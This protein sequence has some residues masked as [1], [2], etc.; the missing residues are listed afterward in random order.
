MAY[1]IRKM[2]AKCGSMT[3]YEAYNGYIGSYFM[4]PSWSLNPQNR[5]PPAQEELVTKWYRLATVLVTCTKQAES[6]LNEKVQKMYKQL[7]QSLLVQLIV[8]SFELRNGKESL[9]SVTGY[10]TLLPELINLIFE[11][12]TQRQKNN[13]LGV[14]VT[15]MENKEKLAFETLDKLLD[16]QLKKSASTADFVKFIPL[17]ILPVVKAIQIQNLI[18]KGA[19]KKIMKI[20]AKLLQLLPINISTMQS[21]GPPTSHSLQIKQGL[22]FLKVFAANQI[23]E[24]YPIEI[25]VKAKLRDY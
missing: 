14:L 20:L 4:K 8:K 23:V 11:S 12:L 7:A 3:I 21:S 2:V 16:S 13:L 10:D 22:D 24:D 1:L 5:Q 17:F 18:Y 15:Q 25:K 9:E 19:E 6:K